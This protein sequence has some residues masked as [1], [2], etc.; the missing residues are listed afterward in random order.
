VALFKKNFFSKA[1]ILRTLSSDEEV[2]K[3]DKAK[4]ENDDGV[5]K[6][7]DENASEEDIDENDEV[8]R[9]ADIIGSVLKQYY[10]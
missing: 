4:N 5:L 10:F 2:P 7:H 1:I 3:T 8:E 6:T 9:R